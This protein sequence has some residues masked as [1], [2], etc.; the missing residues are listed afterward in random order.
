[1]TGKFVYY[2]KTEKIIYCGNQA[3]V[4]ALFISDS[5][6]RFYIIDRIPTEFRTKDTINVE[7]S[8]KAVEQNGCLTF[9]VSTVY[10]I[11]CIKKK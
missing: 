10:K 9:G 2:K 1:M 4:N 11:K 5:V 8:L 3:K 7:I 6:S